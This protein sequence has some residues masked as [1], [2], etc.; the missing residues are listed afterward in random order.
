MIPSLYFLNLDIPSVSGLQFW[1]VSSGSYI[2]CRSNAPDSLENNVQKVMLVNTGSLDLLHQT[3]C[4]T[5]S[6]YQFHDKNLSSC[7]KLE[8][9]IPHCFRD[10]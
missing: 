2:W 4:P 6:E 8:T 7:L 3:G 10:I 5:H 1:G 9:L